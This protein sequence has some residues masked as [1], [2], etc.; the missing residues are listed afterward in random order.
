[1]SIDDDDRTDRRVDDET[2]HRPDRS[3]SSP[4]GRLSPITPEEAVSWYLRRRRNELAESSLYTHQSSLGHFL[5]WTEHVGIDN[6]NEL[7]G[8]KLQRYLTW[9]VEEAPNSV[10]RLAP[11]SEKTQ[12]DIT[13][14]FIEHCEAIDAVHHVL[15]EKILPFRVKEA[16]EVRDEMLKMERIEEILHYLETY[17]YASRA[18]VLW[19]ILAESGARIGAIRSLDLT[20][21]MP[22]SQSLRFRY[23]PEEGTSLK[24]DQGSERRVGLLRDGTMT[25]IQDYIDTQR[26][27]ITDEYG[28]QPLLA[29][30]N[31]RVG[32]STIRKTVYRWSC[33]KIL[34]NKCSHGEE[35]TSSDAWRCQNNAYPHMVRSGVITHFLREE[36][37]VN[38]VSDRC[39]VS[40]EVIKK[41]YDGRSEEE[42]MDIRRT[43]IG[44][45]LS[46]N[47]EDRR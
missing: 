6:L 41:H 37:P 9:R 18:H 33:P 15:H 26:E 32:T 30:H 17:H 3:E 27:D 34:G 39:D 11:K 16:D 38:Y 2:S 22:E 19:A 4:S 36:V 29:T 25:A 47:R 5:R 46:E 10:D 24:N 42:R 14:K 13:R 1:M 31:G 20:D 45:R 44:K 12:I 8:R 28:R 40:P 21:F 7:N 35:M 43:E 23:R